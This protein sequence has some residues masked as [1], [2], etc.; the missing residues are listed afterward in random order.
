[1]STSTTT[2][3]CLF[4]HADR[5]ATA[6]KELAQAGISRESITA[7]AARD[8]NNCMLA[9]LE[10]MGVPARD[11]QHLREGLEAGGTLVTVSTSPQHVGI[12]EKIFGDNEA[13]KIDDVAASPREPVANHLSEPTSAEMTAI[14]IVEEELQVG[15]RTVD[16]GGVHIYRHVVEIP[17]EQSIN[18]REEH[19]TV[20]RHAV[21]RPAT[22]VDLDGQGNRTIELTETAEEAVISKNAHVVEEVLVGRQIGEHTEH[23]HDTVRHTEV[24]VEELPSADLH[25][26]SSATR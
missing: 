1:M 3:L 7:I 15:K 21:D 14:P 12:V 24:E 4:H 11:I 17:V 18:L 23:I 13:G 16:R 25:V 20:D 10:T 2:L 6:L 8:S 9:S 26:N 22:Q 19:V 5:A